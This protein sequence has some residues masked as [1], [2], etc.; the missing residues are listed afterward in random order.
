[1]LAGAIE[2]KRRHAEGTGH[3]RDAATRQQTPRWPGATRRGRGPPPPHRALAAWVAHLHLWPPE[4]DRRT[5]SAAPVL[6]TTGTSAQR[7]LAGAPV[8]WGNGHGGPGLDGTAPQQHC[9]PCAHRPTSS[10]WQQLSGTATWIF[11]LGDEPS[12]SLAPGAAGAFPSPGDRTPSSTQWAQLGP[13]WFPVN[14][15]LLGSLCVA[16]LLP[17]EPGPH[18]SGALTPVMGSSVLVLSLVSSVLGHYQQQQ[19]PESLWTLLPARQGVLTAPQVIRAPCGPRRCRVQLG[20]I[21]LGSTCTRGTAGGGSR[22]GWMEW[23]RGCC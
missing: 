11:M 19:H 3:G 7:G 21:G 22:P 10:G 12:C 2:L 17:S 1:M 4:R 18:S 8:Q 20:R 5:L 6:A 13:L 9:P 16:R 23:G 15:M 14:E